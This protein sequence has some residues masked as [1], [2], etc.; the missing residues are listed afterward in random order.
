M[1]K[2]ENEH[3]V[4]GL[5]SRLKESLKR[6]KKNAEEDLLE[7]EVNSTDAKDTFDEDLS[8]MLGKHLQMAAESETAS[9]SL[10]EAEQESAFEVAELEIVADGTLDPEEITI[11]TPT[12]QDV[13]ENA[14]E[15]ADDAVDLSNLDALLARMT[16]AQRALF[17]AEMNATEEQ[18]APSLRFVPEE[19]AGMPSDIEE[20][21]EEHIEENTEEESGE[22]RERV[23]V[24]S[25]EIDHGTLDEVDDA[26]SDLPEEIPAQEAESESETLTETVTPEEKTPSD[27]AS[28][29]AVG[30]SDPAEEG[31]IYT[32]EVEDEDYDLPEVDAFRALEARMTPEQRDR[33]EQALLEA[34]QAEQAEREVRRQAARA[35]SA[36]RVAASIEETAPALTNVTAE[37]AEAVEA[38]ETVEA[39]EPT[40]PTVSDVIVPIEETVTEQDTVAA[41]TEETVASEG[42]EP[43]PI[44]C[45]S[46]ADGEMPS[47]EPIFMVA[48]EGEEAEDMPAIK[49]GA[50]PS[51]FTF[52]ELPE[53]EPEPEPESESESALD[54]GAALAALLSRMSPEQLARFREELFTD[55]GEEAEVTET[56]EMSTE[57]PTEEPTE[58]PMLETVLETVDEPT[59][60]PD[61]VAPMDSD[62]PVEFVPAPAVMEETAAAEESEA[63]AAEMPLYAMP[64][65][66]DTYEEFVEYVTED[67]PSYDL[68]S[69]E[70]TTV[71]WSEPTEQTEKV[72]LD[73]ILEEYNTKTEE[74]EAAAT[75]SDH[76]A[77]EDDDLYSMEINE[78]MTDE[79]ISLML[80]LGYEKELVYHLG[81]ERV[82]NAKR[83]N[84]TSESYDPEYNEA[85]AY[86]GKEYR[87]RDQSDHIRY[88]YS[89]ERRHIWARLIGTSAFALLLFLYECCGVFRGAFG[90]LFDPAHYPVIAVMVGW[91]LLIF[92]AAFSWKQLYRGI[93]GV[94]SLEPDNHSM[95]SVVVA[96]VMFANILM[97]IVLKGSRLYLYNFPAAICL[98]C[99]VLCDLADVCREELTFEV[100]SQDDNK[101]VAEPITLSN[102]YTDMPI[103]PMDAENANPMSARNA[104]Y[105]RR[106]GFV[107]HYFRRTNRKTRHAQILNFVFLPLVAFSIV[108]GVITGLIG[109]GAVAALNTVVVTILLCMPLSYTVIHTLPLFYEARRLHRQG[110]AIVGENSVEEYNQYATVIFEDKDL[111]PP[112]LIKTK[113]LKLYENNLIYSVILKISLLFREIGG[114]INEVL[115]LDSEEMKRFVASGQAGSLA[116][117]SVTLNRMT[118]EGVIATLNDGSEVVAGSADFLRSRGIDIRPTVRDQQLLQSGEV[119]I[120]YLAFDGELGARFYVDYQPDPEFEAMAGMLNEDEFRVAVRT[121]D[122]GI[123]EDMIANKCLN[124]NT[125]IHTVRAAVNELTE[126]PKCEAGIDSGLV[127]GDDPR[128]MLLPLR[129]IR[130]LRRL[131]RFVL[132]LYFI[133][134]LVNMAVA[135]VLTVCSVIGDM[136]SLFVSL[137]MLV[138]LAASLIMTKLFLNK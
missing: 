43:L 98:L 61:P 52:F 70:E 136:S 46:I 29:A 128:K 66:A 81:R 133:S 65:E 120:L 104:V 25:A 56:A 41:M 53:S 91:Q 26:Y 83:R 33:F 22:A 49:V 51:A 86:D 114:P 108:L 36:E 93:R 105:V 82:E 24:L 138:W 68:V 123:C 100:I 3:E 97:S 7:A 132:K 89:A 113:G 92:A 64:E 50:E 130:N 106:A 126:K 88:R 39:V 6:P 15:Q 32:A 62:D 87:H 110:C 18:P 71:L 35:A 77:I 73:D 63:A 96:I 75:A 19:T 124:E 119:S 99:M 16:P 121:L 14:E 90:G 27:L 5:L 44:V 122:P 20:H 117:G 131:Y 67:E 72:P 37:A 40:A 1:S 118:E 69:D 109:N 59:V 38:I 127:C 11:S 60:D 58:E 102:T 79:E 2:K 101:Y 9:S 135:V 94:F 129:A 125:A 31:E 47:E 84:T 42:D 57:T 107:K 23:I 8:A 78:D 74:T 137:Y 85:Y 13:E 115:D 116:D 76:D 54:E 95:T 111:F 55:D 4:S 17:E 103:D 45:D 80:G 10:S 30:E 28:D 48:E 112:T 12:V 21:I 134:M 34:R